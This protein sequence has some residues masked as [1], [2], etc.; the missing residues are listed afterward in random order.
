MTDPF[1]GSRGMDNP[2]N[3][4]FGH[5]P[6]ALENATFEL[7]LD[8]LDAAVEPWA[9]LAAVLSTVRAPATANELD[10][11][12]QARQLYRSVLQDSRARGSPSGVRRRRRVRLGTAVGCVSLGLLSATGAAAAMDALPAP[13]Q[14][15]AHVALSVVGVHVPGPPP[16]KPSRPARDSSTP[17]TRLSG[18][19]TTTPPALVIVPGGSGAGVS[20]DGSSASDGPGGPGGPGG[21]PQSTPTSVVAPTVPGSPPP[22]A[23]VVGPPPSTVTPAA[24]GPHGTG[25]GQGSGSGQG[26]GTGNG[27][28]SKQGNGNA[29]GSAPP[30]SGTRAPSLLP[31][32]WPRSRV[33][34]HQ[35]D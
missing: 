22:G 31:A 35:G 18:D 1:A 4:R 20:S 10:G 33:A 12:A 29:Q 25:N 13:A 9:A 11:E 23:G 15:A 7:L 30:P 6:S 27:Q 14:W 17:T 3:D 8:G 26:T 24:P 34:A 2:D 19:A 5:G 16:S 28:G 32:A 21:V